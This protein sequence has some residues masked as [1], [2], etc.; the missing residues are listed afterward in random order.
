MSSRGIEKGRMQSAGRLTRMGTHVMT[1]GET[2]HVTAALNKLRTPEERQDTRHE[3]AACCK[4]T[5]TRTR[6][7]T[8]LPK[9]QLSPSSAQV[10]VVS[11]T[12]DMRTSSESRMQRAVVSCVPPV[13][14]H[15]APRGSPRPTSSS[16]RTGGRE[17]GSSLSRRM[18][19][20]MTTNRLDAASPC[21]H[22]IM[23]VY[24]ILL[25]LPGFILGGAH[26]RDGRTHSW[27]PGGKRARAMAGSCT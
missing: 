24:Q 27:G 11:R 9:H 26:D 17:E 7:C 25:T 14:A 4:C 5:E 10:K 13:R 15:T 8:Q 23:R 6:R 20:L 12:L 19:P 21:L 3:Y 2:L 22:Y 18:R 1:E 16:T